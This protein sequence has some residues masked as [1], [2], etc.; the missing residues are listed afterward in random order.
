MLRPCR[1]RLVGHRQAVEI[2]ADDAFDRAG[3]DRAAAIEQQAARAE[4]EH[5]AHVVAD[6]DHRAAVAHHLADLAEA[7][8]LKRQIAD[9]EHFVDDE[10]VGS[11]MRGDGEREAH[12]HAARIALDRRIEHAIDFGEG[13][14]RVQIAVDVALAEAEDRAVQIDVLAAGQLGMEAGAH[15]QQA[16][17]RARA[18]PRVRWSAPSRATGSS[19]ACSCRRRSARSP[20]TLRLA[21]SRT[22]RRAAPT[23]RVLAPPRARRAPSIASSTARRFR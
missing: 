11:K 16:G 21:R 22:T 20:R 12:L 2:G 17:D 4:L 3:G 9:R 1:S 5:R 15:F 8:L 23:A 19:A 13:D 14:D 7:L 10:D 6:E 18:A